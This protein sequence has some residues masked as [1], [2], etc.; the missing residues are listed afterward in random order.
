MPDA[1]HFEVGAEN[2]IP[3]REQVLR[4]DDLIGADEAILTFQKKAR[5]IA[6]GQPVLP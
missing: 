6:I 1:V 3:V 4:D 2:S 5:A